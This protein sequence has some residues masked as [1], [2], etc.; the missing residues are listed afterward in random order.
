MVNN[1]VYLKDRAITV[2]ILLLDTDGDPATGATVT[3][4]VYDEAHAAFSNPTVNE[5]STSGVYHADFTPDAEG[6][7]SVVFD[8]AD[9]NV[10]APMAFRVVDGWEETTLGA[11]VAV[12]QN[13]NNGIW[14]TTLITIDNKEVKQVELRLNDLA[15]G[16]GIT[17]RVY[18]QL[19]V[20]GTP[21]NSMIQESDEYS[22]GDTDLVAQISYLQSVHA[23][24]RTI[25][26]CG[27]M[28]TG[29]A[30]V[31]VYGNYL[32]RTLEAGGFS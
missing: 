1:M 13:D 10:S 28:T 24:D 5:I 2:F 21:T 12:D 30:S 8:C 14:G 25:L 27:K 3:C 19:D 9:P 26:V 17:I 23:T 31:T 4:Q 11:G 29:A 20:N 16:E 32:E 22:F 7:W 18:K 6:Y 15:S